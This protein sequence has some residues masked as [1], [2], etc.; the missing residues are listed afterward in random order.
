[1]SEVYDGVGF[2]P[3]AR[4]LAAARDG[5]QI[6]GAALVLAKTAITAVGADAGR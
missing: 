4:D 6:G 1:M 2:P 3:L 5:A